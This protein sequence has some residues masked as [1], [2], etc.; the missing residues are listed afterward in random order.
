MKKN[1]NLSGIG[2]A[3]FAFEIGLLR[4]WQNLKKVRLKFEVG[5][6]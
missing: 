5:L 3:K 4:V 1:D 2:F 6:S